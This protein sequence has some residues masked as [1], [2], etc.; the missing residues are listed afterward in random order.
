MTICVIDLFQ[1]SDAMMPNKI[2]SLIT[3]VANYNTAI[4]MRKNAAYTL[5]YYIY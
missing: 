1:M 2:T 5:N 3:K 4:L